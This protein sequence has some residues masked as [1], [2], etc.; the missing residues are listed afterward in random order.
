MSLLKKLTE[1]EKKELEQVLKN[2]GNPVILANDPDPDQICGAVS[3][4]EFSLKHWGVDIKIKLGKT[5]GSLNEALYN[6]MKTAFKLDG[7][8]E[9]IAD[10]EDDLGDV[11]LIDSSKKKR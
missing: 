5:I 3:F 10:D 9:F 7:V 4:R 11:I 2:M 6:F 1:K 8:I